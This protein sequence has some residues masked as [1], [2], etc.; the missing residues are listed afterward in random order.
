MQV[1]ADRAAGALH[2]LETL[3][4]AIPALS[5]RNTRPTPEELRA[6][7]R[8]ASESL[9]DARRAIEDKDAARLET[10]L[11]AFRESYGAVSEAAKKVRR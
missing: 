11:A 7:L 4:P 2:H 3:G 5:V 1:Q 6:H 9:G 10:A 8:A